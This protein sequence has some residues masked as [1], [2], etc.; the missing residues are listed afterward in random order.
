MLWIL[1]NQCWLTLYHIWVFYGLKSHY[2]FQSKWKDILIWIQ[3]DPKLQHHKMY[4][5]FCVFLCNL[6]LVHEISLRL[7]IFK[8]ITL[9]ALTTASR[10]QKRLAHDLRYMCLPI[11]YFF[12][13]QK[14]LKTCKPGT[15]SADTYALYI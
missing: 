5:K 15:Q 4:Q 3:V 13:I 12:Q 1:I 10:A 9:I 6:M 14:L 7:L 2:Y 8:L 11:S